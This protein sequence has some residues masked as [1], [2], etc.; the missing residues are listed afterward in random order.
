MPLQIFCGTYCSAV[1]CTVAHAGLPKS[2]QSQR[3]RK[4][5]VG[6]FFIGAS[7]SIGREIW[8]L[9]YAGFFVANFDVPVDVSV[10]VNANVNVDANEKNANVGIS[11]S[12]SVIFS[13][14]VTVTVSVTRG[15]RRLYQ[16]GLLPPTSK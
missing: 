3:R 7:I 6:F 9:L 12:V 5:L 8:C 10:G 15:F 13:V 16:E 4:I 14:R 1:E 11:V 2:H